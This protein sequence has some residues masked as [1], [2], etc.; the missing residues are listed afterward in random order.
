MMSHKNKYVIYINLNI[1]Y[2]S[3]PFIKYVQFDCVGSLKD[4]SDRLLLMFHT[5]TDEESKLYTIIFTGSM[6]IMISLL[7]QY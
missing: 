6:D 1:Y 5:S 4:S 7:G 3:Y 2:R